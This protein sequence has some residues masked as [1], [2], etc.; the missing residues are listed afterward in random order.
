MAMMAGGPAVE[1]N[2]GD[3][4]VWLPSGFPQDVEPPPQSSAYVE[5]SK[6][7]ASWAEDMENEFDGH[8]TTGTYEV[9]K[10]PRGLKPVG[11]KWVF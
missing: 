8:K 2:I 7:K 5:C 4:R 10:P 11:A 3:L 6:Y 1:D 9:A